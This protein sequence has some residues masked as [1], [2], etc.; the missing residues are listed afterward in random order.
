MIGFLVIGFLVFSS[1]VPMVIDELERKFVY[2]KDDELGVFMEGPAELV[3]N[4][5]I[6]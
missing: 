3:F 1:P 6:Q 5:E 4:G 2:E